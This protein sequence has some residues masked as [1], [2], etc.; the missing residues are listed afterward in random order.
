MKGSDAD[1]PT[2]EHRDGVFVDV[3]DAA[4][5]RETELLVGHIDELPERQTDAVST[6]LVV[7][8]VE[9]DVVLLVEPPTPLVVVKNLFTVLEHEGDVLGGGV[10]ERELDSRDVGRDL[11][12]ERVRHGLINVLFTNEDARCRLHG[13]GHPGRERGKVGLDGVADADHSV[14]LQVFHTFERHGAVVQLEVADVITK[15]GGGV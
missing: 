2:E 13:G 10:V 14:E 15:D 9:R 4:F 8:L 12:G 1:H 7:Q 11:E 6:A 3:G 5:E